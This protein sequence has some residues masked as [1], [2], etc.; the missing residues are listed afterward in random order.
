MWVLFWKQYKFSKM[1]TFVS[2]IGALI[3]YGG[4]LCI[5]YGVI[6]AALI[7]I[8]IGVGIHFGAEQI[9]FSAWKKTVRKNGLEEQIRQGDLEVAAKLINGTTDKKI[10]NYVVSLNPGAAALLKQEPEK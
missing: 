9:A 2:V 3:R 8:A 7:C 5:F 6:P 1:A 4:V 10:Q